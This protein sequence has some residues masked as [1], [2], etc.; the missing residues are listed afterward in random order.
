MLRGKWDNDTIEFRPWERQQRGGVY[1]GIRAGG[2]SVQNHHGHLDLGGFVLDAED[3]RWAVDIPPV[4]D[5]PPGYLADYDLP[6]YFDVTLDRR[7]RYYRT[8]T[9]GHNTLVIDGWNQPLDIQAE[10]VAFAATLDLAIAVVDL[11]AAYPDCLRLRRGFALIDRRHVLIVDEIT[12]KYGISVVWQMHTKAS[13]AV[14]G[15]TARLALDTAAGAAKEFFARILEPGTAAF[16]LR[17]A[18]VTQPQE[19]PNTGIQKLVVPLSGVAEP[20]R[21]AVYFSP[22]SAPPAP[23]PDPLS[24]PLW[25]WIAWTGHRGRYQNWTG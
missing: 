18:T 6:G 4:D 22:E 25:S 24:G 10:I 5:P 23:L 14:T 8:G 12:P 3:V 9:I 2:N 1:L 15:T 7:F 19:A 21:L 20:T 17:P 16:E 11:T 13:A